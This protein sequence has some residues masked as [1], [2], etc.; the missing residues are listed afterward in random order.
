M[1]YF[2]AQCRSENYPYSAESYCTW[3]K[4]NNNGRV[5]KLKKHF[6]MMT[7]GDKALCYVAGEGYFSDI[8]EV[9]KRLGIG[10]NNEAILAMK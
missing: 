2:I 8:L 7:Q 6:E 1:N 9:G 10:E 4:H 5:R 3:H